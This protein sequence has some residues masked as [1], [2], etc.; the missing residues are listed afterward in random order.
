MS[1]HRLSLDTMIVGICLVLR[2]WYR[3]RLIDEIDFGLIDTA[4]R[5]ALDALTK[6]P[7]E[8]QQTAAATACLTEPE[9]A[10]ASD[11]SNED[12]EADHE[13]WDTERLME[14]MEVDKAHD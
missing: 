4:E 10:F 11:E 14:M 5:D 6:L 1:G 3:S 13:G 7:T 12:N 8:D 9:E 2:S